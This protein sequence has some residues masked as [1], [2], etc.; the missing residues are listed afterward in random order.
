[1]NVYQE[2]HEKFNKVK[3]D[4]LTPT[5]K[6]P[7]CLS[8]KRSLGQNNDA[9]SNSYLQK[10]SSYIDIT[11]R[12][13]HKIIKIYICSECNTEYCDPWFTTD[14]S[15]LLYNI[16]F[17]QHRN[18]WNKFND[19]ANDDKK[20]GLDSGNLDV[21][22]EYIKKFSD[23][24]QFYGELNCPFHGFFGKFAKKLY[25]LDSNFKDQSLNH[26]LRMRESYNKIPFTGYSQNLPK[27]PVSE[28]PKKRSLIIEPSSMF[29]GSNCS[30]NNVSCYSTAMSLF[31]I[32]KL[33]FTDIERQNIKFD[34]IGAFNVIDLM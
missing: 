30:Y 16:I 10:M 26:L 18:G 9:Q 3:S 1:M 29:W 34:V 24:I 32:N 23:K 2:I 13:L 22:W 14:T 7:V 12:E 4:F 17:G 28:I 5:N 6:C 25:E 11:E 27:E 31:G 19:W 20:I 33:N 15:S 21:I 8:D